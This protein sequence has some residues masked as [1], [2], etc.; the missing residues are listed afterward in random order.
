MYG[1]VQIFT[2]HQRDK[3]TQAPEGKEGKALLFARQTSKALHLQVEKSICWS[4]PTLDLYSAYLY[5]HKAK[6]VASLV[7]L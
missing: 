6:H 5:S 1:V 7:S 4:A 2:E 3:S